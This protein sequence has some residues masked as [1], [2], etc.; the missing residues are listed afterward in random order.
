MLGTVLSAGGTEG[1]VHMAQLSHRLVG[2]AVNKPPMN[3]KLIAHCEKATRDIGRRVLRGTG[4]VG[5]GG[6]SGHSE[7]TSQGG[8]V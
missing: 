4:T 5:Q 8:A 1:Q 2:E 7:R 3:N 6:T